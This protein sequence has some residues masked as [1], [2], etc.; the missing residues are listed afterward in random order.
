[1]PA[2]LRPA[3]MFTGTAAAGAFRSRRRV[4]ASCA[5]SMGRGSRAAMLR[6]RGRDVAVPGGAAVFP[7]QG[8]ADQFFDIPQ[9]SDLLSGDQRD[10]DAIS[11]GARGAADA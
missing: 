7:R 11:A 1:M 2:R 8:N 9:V 3:A 10:R 5:M 4:M 6:R